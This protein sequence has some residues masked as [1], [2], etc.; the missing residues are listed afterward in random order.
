MRI[1]YLCDEV[2]PESYFFDFIDYVS[3][4]Y[5]I[6]HMTDNKREY[7]AINIQGSYVYLGLIV[8]Y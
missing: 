3:K 4:E 1:H 7:Y 6:H 2:V 8:D 5:T